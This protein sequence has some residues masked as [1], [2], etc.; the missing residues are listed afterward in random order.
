[1][2]SNLRFRLIKLAQ[3]QPTMRRHLLP[4]LKKTSGGSKTDV[5]TIECSGDMADELVAL[6]SS[7]KWVCDIGA[8]RGL[9]FP[10]DGEHLDVDLSKEMKDKGF[11]SQFG[12]DGD[13]ADHIV[14]IKIS[15]GDK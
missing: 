10:M 8:S 5:I 15:R 14:D 2:K 12:F 13:G 11:R 7:I 6:L 4:I 9:R 1:M 3:D